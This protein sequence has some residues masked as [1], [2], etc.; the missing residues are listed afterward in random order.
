MW[1]YKKDESMAQAG[2]PTIGSVQA[3]LNALVMRLNRVDQ[4]L[5]QVGHVLHDDVES[6]EGEHDGD[7]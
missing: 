5:R 7:R 3:E 2:Y 6:A 1:W 4:Q